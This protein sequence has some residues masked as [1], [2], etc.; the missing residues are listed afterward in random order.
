M[1]IKKEES[2]KFYQKMT[3]LAAKRK[4]PLKAMFELTYKCNFSCVHCYVVPD[5]NKKELTTEQV[6][7]VLNQL[8]DA[9][10][11]HIGFS[12]GEPFIREDIFQIL[13]YAKKRG[14]RISLL[15]NGFLMDEKTADK[16][17]SLG[18]SLNHVDVSVLG[19]TE[20]TFEKLTRKRGSYKRVMRA[21]K[22]LKERGADVQIKATLMKL[23]KNEFLKIKEIAEK[24]NTLFRYGPMITPKTNGDASPCRLQVE[25]D[26]VFQIKRKLS[27]QK[28]VINEDFYK[29]L[30][31]KRVGRESLFR[32]GAGQSEVTISPY[33]EMNLCLEIHLYVALDQNYLTQ[34]RFAEIYEQASKSAKLING[35]IRYLSKTK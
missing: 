2:D 4:F 24:F 31:Y 23:N 29:S 6:K 10:C 25:P 30:H 9:G 15:T 3:R 1:A 18:T 32:C 11:F 14:F 34:N 33:G 19:V 16:I 12:G 17:A 28:G 35:F 21:I 7:E 20:E 26:E 13:D 22:L 8:K 5:K 27:K